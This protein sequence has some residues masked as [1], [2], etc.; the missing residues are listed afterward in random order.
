MT[1][2]RNRATRKAARRRGALARLTAGINSGIRFSDRHGDCLHDHHSRER[3]IR[4]ADK[5]VVR[6]AALG[7][8]GKPRTKK[9]RSGRVRFA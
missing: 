6:I 8:L 2:I 1:L 7:A 4:E 3:A 5:L 9:D